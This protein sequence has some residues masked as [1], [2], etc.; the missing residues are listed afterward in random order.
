[1]R[2]VILALELAPSE[3]SVSAVRKKLGL[4]ARQIDAKFGVRPV[5][6]ERNEYAIR[7]DADV[8]QRV[9]GEDARSSERR[10]V[11]VALVH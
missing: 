1:M 5:R 3:A 10:D 8:A 4:R 6:E 11:R 7:V 2:K 9:R